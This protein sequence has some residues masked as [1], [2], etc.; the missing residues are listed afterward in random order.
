MGTTGVS[1]PAGFTGNS[2]FS[3]DLAQVISRAVSIASLPMQQ[4]QGEQSK[5]AGQQTELQ[6][7]SGQFQSLQSALDG[8]NGSV[9]SGLYSATVGNNSILSASTSAGIAAGTYTVNVTSTGSQTN[10]ISA[11]GL[12]TVTDPSA[13]NISSSTAYTLTLNGQSFQLTDAD[14][15]L[16]DLAAAINTSGANVQATIVNVGSSSA[17][18]YRLSI[19]SLD[20]AP[21]SIQLNDGTNDLL[22]TLST[23][24]YVTYQVDGQPSTPV[25]SD[26]RTLTISPGL[27]V[28]VLE[29]GA[30][31]VTVSQNGS[32][33]SNALSSFANA[34]NAVIDELSQSRGQNGGALSGQSIVYSLSEVLRSIT[35]YTSTSSGAGSLADLGLTFDQNGHLQFDSSVFAQNTASSLNNALTFLGSESSGGFLQAANSLITS[36][37]DPTTGLLPQE[38]QATSDEITSLGQKISADQ[39]QV[40][41]LQQNLTKQ[42]AAADALISSLE[43]Q[44]TQI[45]NLFSA[46][47]QA[48]KSIS[49]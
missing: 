33:I 41:Q 1:T 34:Y 35:N 14:G 36:V 9:G 48:S 31:S 44:V 7:L 27:S 17:P 49:G 45:T 20:Y 19:Q 47:Q 39:D 13:G 29:P 4:L 6:T 11:N 37:T 38:S 43:Q 18:D 30:T 21:D 46:M 3:S 40:T 8:I 10:T 25:N 2:A 12:T 16:N 15:S 22:S 23:G 26:S 42:M 5:I 32:S 28:S 24:S